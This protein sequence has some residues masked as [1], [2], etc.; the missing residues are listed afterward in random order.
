VVTPFSSGVGVTISGKWDAPEGNGTTLAAQLSNLREGRAHVNFHTTQFLGGEIRDNIPAASAL[1]DL[2]VAG[3]NGS[4]ETRATVLRK[5]AEQEEL[6]LREFN[7]TSAL[8]GFFSYYRRDMDVAT[9]NRLLNRLN[10][11][12]GNIG[13]EV[14]RIFITADEYRQRFGLGSVVNTAPVAAGDAATANI[15]TP[16]TIDVL[17]ND[18]DFENNSLTIDSVV[19]DAGGTPSIVNNKVLFTPALNFTGVATFQYTVRDNGTTNLSTTT[20]DDPLTGTATV[21]VTATQG[22]V[23]Q[24][25]S[26][27]YTVNENVP[28]A[29]ITI[30]RTG[31]S[32]GA[33]TLQFT[34]SNGTAGA[35]DYT[36]TTTP[37][38]FADGQTSQTVNIPINNDSIDEPDET[39]NLTLSSVTGTG[40]LGAQATAVLTILDNDAQPSISINDV[41]VTEGSGGTVN[42]VFI[43]TLSG[44]SSLPI[45][46]NVATAD[47]TATSASDYQALPNTVLNFAL[48]ELVKIVTVAVNGDIVG[49]TNETFFVNLTNAQNATISDAQA[50]GTIT[51]DDLQNVQFG[52]SNYNINEGATNTTLG[53]GSLTVDVTRTGDTSAASTVK[54]FTSDL[55]G[56]NECNVVNGQ[57]NQRCDYLLV[58][59]TLRFAAGETSKQIQIPIIKDGYVEGNEVFTIG[60]QNPTG[61]NIGVNNQASVTIIDTG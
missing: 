9:L 35:A 16:I 45:T 40:Q 38:N 11:I 18:T 12:N 36:T 41:S 31:G 28:S 59:A 1:R 53:F 34:T 42:A 61:A 8:L 10:S 13:Q 57:A 48:G 3:L 33:T 22:G 6:K 43:V 24:F 26:L 25:S 7:A 32:I 54:Y 51:N 46:V 60:L 44:Q 2:L 20:L 5:V 55:S 50:A 15:N 56:G 49:E 39:V 21:T 37:V 23:I 29:L 47:G 19:A 27:T 4:T 17:A 58:G 30:T 52:A 14:A